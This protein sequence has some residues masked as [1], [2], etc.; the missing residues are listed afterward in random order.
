M[1]LIGKEKQW[2]NQHGVIW[3]SFTLL[4]HTWY[5]LH[6]VACWYSLSLLFFFLNHSPEYWSSYHFPCHQAR[7][8]SKLNC[9]ARIQPNCKNFTMNG[10][11][12]INIYYWVLIATL[13]KVDV[14]HENEK[15]FFQIFFFN[16]TLYMQL[17]LPSLD[18]DVLPVVSMKVNT[19]NLG[20]GDLSQSPIRIT[21]LFFWATYYDIRLLFF[22]VR[23]IIEGNFCRCSQFQIQGKTTTPRATFVPYSLW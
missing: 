16:L 15:Q 3:K 22:P 8:K 23:S 19:L 5:L 12:F 9:T 20:W 2:W 17:W 21:L 13:C 7:T 18:S 10:S 14:F 11:R 1:Q 6:F 4:H